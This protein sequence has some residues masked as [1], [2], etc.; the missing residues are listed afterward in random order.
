MA[1]NYTDTEFLKLYRKFVGWEWY[2]NVPTK[3]LFLHCLLRANW[4]AGSWMGI[5]Y[6]P[7][8]FITSLQ[9]LAM[10]TGLS[11][12][13]VRTA[14]NHL[15]ATG[16]V[17]DLRQA[18]FRI[19]TVKN[20]DRYQS[21]DKP[22]D[23]PVTNQR[24][25]IDNRYKNNR[26]IEHKKYMPPTKQDIDDYIFLRH[27]KNVDVDAFMDYNESLGWKM[28]WHKALDQW[29]ENQ[30]KRDDMTRSKN[31]FLNIKKRDYDFEAMERMMED[32]DYDGDLEKYADDY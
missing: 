24:Q 19:I 10:E 8:Q 20:W 22:T 12:R 30:K 21:I 29:V 2:Q 1:W 26:T 23:R 32:E 3:V 18:N 17:S 27:F 14:L 5:N 28:E 6:E 4:K 11:V 9:S 15:K 31:P 13:Q 7:G 25:T 16:E